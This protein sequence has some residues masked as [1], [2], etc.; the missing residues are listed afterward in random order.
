MKI[1]NDSLMSTVRILIE[2]GKTEEALK[3]LK[4]TKKYNK[5][6]GLFLYRLAECYAEL[7]NLQKAEK[8]AE[9]AGL[10]GSATIQSGVAWIFQELGNN[11][12]AIYWYMKSY[13]NGD[14]DSASNLLNKYGIKYPIKLSII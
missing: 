10:Y 14:I 3:A 4:E 7:G 11:P 13:D 8:Y 9:L 12:K 6:N 5:N 2:T 1:D